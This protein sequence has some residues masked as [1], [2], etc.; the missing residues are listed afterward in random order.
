MRKK[1]FQVQIYYSSFCTYEIKATNE[2]NAINL[3]REMDVV[4]AELIRNIENWKEAD[5]ADEVEYKKS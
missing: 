4:K 1:I 3:A 2:E 5:I